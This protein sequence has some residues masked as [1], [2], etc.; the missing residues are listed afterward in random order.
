MV[1][2]QHIVISGASG[3]IGSHL[4]KRLKAN[5]KVVG[6]DLCNE[7]PVLFGDVRRRNIADFIQRGSIVIHCASIA[8]V[9]NVMRNPV[10][11]MKTIIEGTN[12]I[13]EAACDKKASKIINFS[14]SEILGNS[15]LGRTVDLGKEFNAIGARWVYSHSKLAMET[16]T[17]QM[18]QLYR[19]PA[20]NI[21]PFNVFGPG[22]KT[23]GAICRMAKQF[24][25][26]ET[27]EIRNYGEQIRSWTYIDDLIDGVLMLLESDI[28][29]E[30]IPIGNPQNTLTIDLLAREIKRISKSMSQIVNIA[31]TEDDI[32]LRMPDIKFMRK[33]GY[34]PKVDLSLGLEKTIA[35]YR[36]N[37]EL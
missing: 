8:G 17:L 27:V 12:N 6:F 9:D 1:K 24:I 28:M 25:K 33:L 26:N 32:D 36:S 7:S 21:R 29:Y 2:D 3:F 20:L 11:C 34:I 18:A 5:N 19:I 15:I 35:W 31:W 22:Q 14:T 4:M 13:V 16:L 10:G 37:N 30:S 23:G